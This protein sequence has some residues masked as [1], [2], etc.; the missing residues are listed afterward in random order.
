MVL[1]FKHAWKETKRRRKRSVST[2]FGYAVAAATMVILI[3]FIIYAN[4][5]EEKILHG[6][7]TRFIAFIPSTTCECTVR[8]VDEDYLDL[9]E[10]FVT[11]TSYAKLMERNVLNKIDAL[12]VIDD[13]SPFISYRMLNKIN[14]AL[15][16]TIGGLDTS[17]KNAV[18][19]N[20]CAPSDVMEGRFI[21]NGELNVVMVEE[22]YAN[23]AHLKIG[24]NLKIQDKSFEVIGI[25]N[26]EMRPAKADV[27]M[28][29]EDASIVL[30]KKIGE[31]LNGNFNCLL[32]VATD[33]RLL[34][35]AAEE[36]QLILGDN[37][38]VSTS[39]CFKFATKAM[40]IND[41]AIYLAFII[42]LGS[43]ILFSIKTQHG[44]IVERYHDMGILKA[45][46]WMNR[47]ILGMLFLESTIQSVLG[48]II[49]CFVATI[50]IIT[51]PFGQWLDFVPDATLKK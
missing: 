30:N 46:G 49:G 27:Y 9:N 39:S 51:V 5:N 1:L 16:V 42:I 18:Y 3:S 25:L 13:V 10:G 45:I 35:K 2:L 17:N 21:K 11:F 7:G 8:P 12:A 31:A 43:T 48:G 19:K 47:D 24:D 20:C 33:A 6:V 26:T 15:Y 44:N 34:D 32:I 4:S 14:D 22:A 36:V 38:V 50:I 37:A 40:G 23:A 41:K 29:V 28:N